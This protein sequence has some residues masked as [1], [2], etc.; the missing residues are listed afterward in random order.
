[1]STNKNKT[2][3]TEELLYPRYKVTNP[4]PDMGRDGYYQGQIITLRLHDGRQWYQRQKDLTIYE[5]F[6]QNYPHLF[7]SLPWWSDRKPE[8]MPEYVKCVKTPDQKIMPGQLFK[9]KWCT[10][11]AGRAATGQWVV[12]DTNCFAPATLA[13]YEQHIN[14]QKTPQ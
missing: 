3:A 2:M 14:Q 6:F 5:A 8:E 1:M 13:E 10:P 12:V 4:W 9:V 11:S 7:Q